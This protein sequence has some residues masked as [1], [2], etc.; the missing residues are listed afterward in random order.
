M[1]TQKEKKLQSKKN[2]APQVRLFVVAWTQPTL[3]EL[4]HKKKLKRSVKMTRPHV[5]VIYHASDEPGQEYFEQAVRAAA[6]N[7]N[8]RVVPIFEGRGETNKAC[9]GYTNGRA[10]G[11]QGSSSRRR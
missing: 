10:D 5:H 4:A 3:A 7:W 1:S 8:S 9:V 6:S 11:A 2:R